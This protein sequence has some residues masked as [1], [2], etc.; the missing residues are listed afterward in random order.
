[1]PS[2]ATLPS[3]ALLPPP[4]TVSPLLFPFLPSH[5]LHTVLAF[6]Q[7]FLSLFLP[8]YL[9]LCKI[10]EAQP[11]GRGKDRIHVFMELGESEAKNKIVQLHS[12]LEGAECSGGIKQSVADGGAVLCGGGERN[13]Q[14]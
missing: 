6:L 9:A 7:I 2:Q 11:W 1:M 3:P 12:T 4:G 8:R 14:F 10:L 13:S 5:Q